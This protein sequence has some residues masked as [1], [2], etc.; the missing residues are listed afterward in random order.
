MR[1][2]L[3]L[4]AIGVVAFAV[5][6]A[7]AGG[8]ARGAQPSWRRS[9]VAGASGHTQVIEFAPSAAPAVRYNDPERDEPPS[10]KLADALIAAVVSASG[11]LSKPAPQ[12]DARLFA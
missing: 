9:G 12:A 2:R 10:S 11:E 7:C 1:Q 3:I 4:G 5:I 8:A 6:A